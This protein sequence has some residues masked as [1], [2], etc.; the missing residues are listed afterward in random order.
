MN[1]EIKDSHYELAGKIC[2]ALDLNPTQLMEY[3]MD[4]MQDV[5]SNYERQKNTGVE[6]GNFKEILTNLSFDLSNLRT[7]EERLIVSTNELLGIKEYIDAGVYNIDPDFYDRRFCYTMGYEFSVDAT[8]M[9]S[10]KGL[11]INVEMNQDYIEVSHVLYLHL[12]IAENMEISDKKVSDASN[13]AQEFIRDINREEFSPFVNFSVE[14]FPIVD[15]QSNRWQ[16]IGIKLIIK[17]DKAAYV[18]SIETITRII[19]EVNGIVIAKI[20]TK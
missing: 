13:F 8:N 6:K 17:A 19:K 15:S 3:L 20:S 16:T 9:D 10:Y 11:L 14:V 4:F 18:P 1:V 2:N 7:I 12:P 5:Y